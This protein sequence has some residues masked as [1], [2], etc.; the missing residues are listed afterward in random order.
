MRYHC[1]DVEHVAIPGSL[2]CCCGEVETELE[3][4]SGTV[5][6][7]ERIINE[8]LPVEQGVM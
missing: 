8:Q 5:G 4:F 2:V 1:T 7:L 3:G 6:E